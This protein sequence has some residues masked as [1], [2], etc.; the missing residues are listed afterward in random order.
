M[1]IKTEKYIKAKIE[2]QDSE[3]ETF[4]NLLEFARIYMDTSVSHTLF[5]NSKTDKMRVMLTQLFDALA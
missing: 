4:T 5:R 2:M 3:V 1:E